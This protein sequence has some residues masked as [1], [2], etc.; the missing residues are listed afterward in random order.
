M[1]ASTG[2]RRGL[3][4]LLLAV[5]LAV[6][7]I[8]VL[9]FARGEKSYVRTVKKSKDRAAE[10]VSHVNLAS[11]YRTLK[12]Y[13]AAND[14]KF[15]NTPEQLVR[16]AGLPEGYLFDPARPSRPHVCIYVA[17]QNEN[18]PGSNVLI[19]EA[20]MRPDGKCQVLRLGGRLELL[21][22]AQTMAAV[23]KTKEHLN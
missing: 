1:K 15:P 13:A 21:S 11:V 16:V 10:T 17:G 20:K 6:A 5:L 12:V 22:Y 7:I 2:H 8:L 18:M 14:G 19:Y 9:Y 3:A 23:D 4:G